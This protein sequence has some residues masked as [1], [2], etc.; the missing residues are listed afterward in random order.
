MVGSVSF[1]TKALYDDFV[2]SNSKRKKV[3]DYIICDED[4]TTVSNMRYDK[5]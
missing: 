4:N 3:K 1:N 2:K 5:E